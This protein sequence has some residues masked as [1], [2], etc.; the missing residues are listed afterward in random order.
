MAITSKE[1]NLAQLS[2]ELKGIGLIADF[3]NPNEKLILV[4]DGY[5]LTEA[6]LEAAIEAHISIS[7][8]EINAE[9]NLQKVALLEKLGITEEEVKLLW[10]I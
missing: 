8:E 5:E 7:E 9:K 10:K 1:I 2:K 6:A 4:A 3:A